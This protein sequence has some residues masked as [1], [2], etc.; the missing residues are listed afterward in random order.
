MSAMIVEED[1]FPML[2]PGAAGLR[3]SAQEFDQAEFVR[4]WR[5]ELIDGVGSQRAPRCCGAP[6]LASHRKSTSTFS[7]L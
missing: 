4:G 6:S 5:Y 2:G 1:L 7:N 3:L